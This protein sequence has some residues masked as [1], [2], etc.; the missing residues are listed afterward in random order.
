[1]ENFLRK[2]RTATQH[3]PNH[4]CCT[5]LCCAVRVIY[6]I[7]LIY[8]HRTCQAFVCYHQLH[9]TATLGVRQPTTTVAKVI[10]FLRILTTSTI[11][12]TY[13]QCNIISFASSLFSH[14]H[15]LAPYT[16]T[17]SHSKY[18]QHSAFVT[19]IQYSTYY[20]HHRCRHCR[21]LFHRILLAFLFSSIRSFFFFAISELKRNH[22]KEDL[23]TQHWRRMHL[24]VNAL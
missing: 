1:M 20:R 8:R 24:R 23:K 18:N 13:N 5:V 12:I 22:T 15:E 4:M 11:F 17:T 9:N 21:P 16:H 14:F 19:T 10:H 3:T 7:N 6:T 2:Q